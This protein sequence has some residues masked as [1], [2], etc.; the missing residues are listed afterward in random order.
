MSDFS[1]NYAY[2]F[3]HHVERAQRSQSLST[4]EG[5]GPAELGENAPNAIRWGVLEGARGGTDQSQVTRILDGSWLS[6]RG[7]I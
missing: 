4:R 5:A 2:V 3:I 1:R 7:W 6:R